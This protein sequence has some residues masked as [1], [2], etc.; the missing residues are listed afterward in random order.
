MVRGIALVSLIYDLSIGVALFTLRPQLQAWFGLPPAV[1]PIHVD[2]NAI[3]VSFVGLG[4]LL[5]LQDPNRYRAYLWIFGVALKLVG[6]M[7]FIGD[8]LYRGSPAALLLFALSD[9]VVAGL[10][11]AALQ[12][13]PAAS[14]LPPAE[15]QIERDPRRDDEQAGPRD[16][17]IRDDGVHDDGKTR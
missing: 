3:F 12:L 17:G 11:L 2:L 9:G 16:H 14:H 15:P 10:T 6:A 1:P 13:S 4:Y 8:Y 5:P 7:A